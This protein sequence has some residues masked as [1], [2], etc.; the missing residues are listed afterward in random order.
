M[1]S[2]VQIYRVVVLHDFF[3]GNRCRG[4]NL[5]PVPECMNQMGNLGLLFRQNNYN[6]WGLYAKDDEL[7]RDKL[8]LWMEEETSALEFQVEV[9]QNDFFLY[10]DWPG[11]SPKECYVFEIG[12]KEKELLDSEGELHY[13]VVPE[14]KIIVC[15]RDKTLQ[16]QSNRVLGFLKLGF[17]DKMVEN[18]GQTEVSQCKEITI[19]FHALK[20]VWEFI[21]I[22]R[23][24]SVD[25]NLLLKDA[26]GKMEL[27]TLEKFELTQGL[28][29]YR[30]VSSSLIQLKEC[31]DYRVQLWELKQT[32]KRLISSEIPLPRVGEFSIKATKEN[33]QIV[34]KYFYF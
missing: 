32:G 7:Q 34:S 23:D 5:V 30:G 16:K 20:V 12:D 25:Q 26:T 15:R 21:L 11:Y 6:E 14:E 2:Y 33:P 27:E 18:W 3:E 24:S 22:P 29:A 10:T 13:G 1:S 9:S 19:G 31:Y 8:Q 17:S 4:V 28:M